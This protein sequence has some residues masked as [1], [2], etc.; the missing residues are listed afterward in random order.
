MALQS[1]GFWSVRNTDLPSTSRRALWHKVTHF[2]VNKTA[3]FTKCGMQ[4]NFPT[5]Y[6]VFTEHPGETY[7]CGV[8]YDE[9]VIHD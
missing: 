5:Q 2:N 3:A 1:A 4:Y 7:K 9:Y 6:V 8:C